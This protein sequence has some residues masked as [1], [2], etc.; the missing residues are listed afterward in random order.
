MGAVL[1]FLNAFFAA[2]L[3][4]A[5][6]LGQHQALLHALGH[7]SDDAGSGDKAPNPDKKCAEHSLYTA[8]AGAIG[9]GTGCIAAFAAAA[10]RFDDSQ[11]VVVAADARHDY[12]SRAPPATPVRR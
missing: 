3:L 6:P 7:A 4:L 9:S 5:L 11:I 1:R 2:W 12:L 10:T 8:F